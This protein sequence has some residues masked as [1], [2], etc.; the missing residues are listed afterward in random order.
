MMDWKRFVR[1]EEDPWRTVQ[2][3]IT[4]PAMWNLRNYDNEA[5]EEHLGTLEKQLDSLE[6]DVLAV[7]QD[8]WSGG[9]WETDHL[10]PHQ[11]KKQQKVNSKSSQH[12]LNILQEKNVR[13]PCTVT[14]LWGLGGAP[15]KS[16]LDLQAEVNGRPLSHKHRQVGKC[17]LDFDA[18]AALPVQKHPAE[19]I[20]FNQTGMF[21]INVD[22]SENRDGTDVPFKV[23]VRK[24]GREVEE[25]DGVWPMQRMPGQLINVCS[26]T[27]EE[28]DLGFR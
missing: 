3:I 6:D 4:M 19:N 13:A 18:N 25:Y 26:I 16:D 15:H 12:L 9:G 2:D 7:V 10:L 23:I 22:N 17:K 21:E 20:T 14:L 11:V 24:G 8:F 28:Q 1:N 27:V 5:G